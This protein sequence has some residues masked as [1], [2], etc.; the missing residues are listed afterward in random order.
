MIPFDAMVARLAKDTDPALHHAI[1]SLLVRLR[2]AAAL[3]AGGADSPWA[4]LVDQRRRLARWEW[5]GL[6]K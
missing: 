4:A 2:P 3:T 6:V 5:A 1:L